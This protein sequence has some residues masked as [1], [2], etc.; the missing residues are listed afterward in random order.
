MN[1][2]INKIV[3]YIP[4]KKLRNSIRELLYG[5]FNNFDEIKNILLVNKSID[6]TQNNDVFLEN[7]LELDITKNNF[8]L[9]KL[10]KPI[11]IIIPVYNAYEY[12]TP[13]FDSI[14]KN[15]NID[16]RLIIIEDKS[17]DTRVLP[18]LKGMDFQKYNYCKDFIL[19]ENEE[20]LGFIKS[21]NK[22]CEFVHNH[23]VL[24]NTDIVLPN[25]WLNRLVKPLYYSNK[26]IASI[27]PFTN[28]GV[29][30]SYP[31]FLK[32]NNL[33]TNYSLNDIDNAFSDINDTIT[34]KC[35]I[36]SGCGFCM[37]INYNCWND[38]GKLDEENLYIGYGEETDWCFRAINAGYVNILVPN[39]FVYHKGSA[40]FGNIAENLIEKNHKILINRY[41]KHFETASSNAVTDPFKIYRLYATLKL[42]K[43]KNLLYIHYKTIKNLKELNYKKEGY[44]ILF[45]EYNIENLQTWYYHH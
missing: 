23:F 19:I 37:V 26:K 27:T 2:I 3:W 18:L 6:N 7:I 38:I 20:N 45:F 11:D 15:T 12:L 35:I 21:V 5:I 29:F 39:L 31:I 40:S 9:D 32:S 28:S 25:N 8:I 4:I 13:L 44:N 33:I 30:F 34:D 10:D 41:S 1:D 22:A 14:F 17:T 42:L 43:N 16:Y 36:H 24:L